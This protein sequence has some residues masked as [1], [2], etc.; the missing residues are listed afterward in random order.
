MI[1]KDLKRNR[2]FLGSLK[3]NRQ[4]LKIFM[5]HRLEP[6]FQA[7]VV[8]ICFFTRNL[9][10]QFRVKIRALFRSEVYFFKDSAFC[11]N[12]PS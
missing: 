8:L 11:V 7:S 5:G 4:V 12:S 9:I 2:Y 1:S 10:D 3:K 6:S